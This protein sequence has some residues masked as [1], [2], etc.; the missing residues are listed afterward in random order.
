[1][2]DKKANAG[3]LGIGIGLTFAAA[4][5]FLV[6]GLMMPRTVFPWFLGIGLCQLVYLI[7]LGA[8]SWKKKQ[9]KTLQGLLI[10][11]AFVFLLN[12]SCFGWVV[13]S[14]QRES[15][16]MV[17]MSAPQDAPAIPKPGGQP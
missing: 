12:A 7:P 11:A 17:P 6:L 2:E 3:S 14:L 1:V 16:R 15:H 5:V 13:V 9:V 10:G 8:Y 4:I